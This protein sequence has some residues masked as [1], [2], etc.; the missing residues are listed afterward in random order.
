MGPVGQKLGSFGLSISEVHSSAHRRRVQGSVASLEG[1]VNRSGYE[2]DLMSEQIRD[3]KKT[4]QRVLRLKADV[5]KTELEFMILLAELLQSPLGPLDENSVL[6]S[7]GHVYG[8]KQLCVH[9]N[10]AREEE[11]FRSPLNPQDPTNF[12]TTRHDIVCEMVLWLRRWVENF[13]YDRNEPA[14]IKIQRLLASEETQAAYKKMEEENRIPILPT[15]QS[16]RQRRLAARI[17]RMKQRKLE[18]AKTVQEVYQE[19]LSVQRAAEE[20]FQLQ[21]QRRESVFHEI[22]KKIEGLSQRDQERLTQ[23][24]SQVTILDEEIGALDQ[25][26]KE[27]D[28]RQKELGERITEVQQDDIILQKEIN[29]TRQAIKKRNQKWLKDVL[30]MAGTAVACWGTTLVLQEVLQG[31]QITATAAGSGQG[32]MIT[33][34]IPL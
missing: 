1:V 16:E 10:Q 34:E 29:E 14:F 23:I 30:I 15:I 25:Q 21:A 3:W 32:G 28:S 33:I 31:I 5:V 13:P 18:E 19:A 26:N 8:R 9:L 7:D 4:F 2:N 20:Q 22:D 11:R 17:H 12:T 6:G 24:R 27:L